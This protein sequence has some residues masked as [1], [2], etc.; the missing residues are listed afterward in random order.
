MG[1]ICSSMFH[2]YELK[3]SRRDADRNSQT[4]SAKPRFR[5]WS[6]RQSVHLVGHSAGGFVVGECALWLKQH[7]LPAP[8]GRTIFVDRVTMLDTPVP[9]LS[10]YTTL[11]A[12]NPPVVERY[13]STFW[14]H[15]APEIRN[16]PPGPFYVRSALGPISSWFRLDTDGH[17]LALRWYRRRIFPRPGDETSLD[18]YG[19]SA[20]SLSPLLG[21]YQIESVEE[22]LVRN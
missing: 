7:P 16:V 1:S 21:G 17:A 2:S 20:F 10:H 14:G 8:D 3:T 19:T 5:D 13:I 22:S 9:I 18:S 11:I 6:I 15:I 4:A 12:Q